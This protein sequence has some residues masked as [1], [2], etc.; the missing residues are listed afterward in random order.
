MT[1]GNSE[2]RKRPYASPKLVAYGDMASLTKTA[3][4]SQVE[5]EGGLMNMMKR[6]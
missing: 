6:P 5:V 3:T 2:G 1:M 4:G